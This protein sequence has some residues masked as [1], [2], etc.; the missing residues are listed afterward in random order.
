[1]APWQTPIDHPTP[2]CREGHASF[3]QMQMQ[4]QVDVHAA[5]KVECGGDTWR[6][7]HMPIMRNTLVRLCLDGSDKWDGSHPQWQWVL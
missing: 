4:I 3:S 2:P 1:M 5:H 6:E 7:R